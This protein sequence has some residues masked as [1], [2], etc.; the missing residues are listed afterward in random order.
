M[1]GLCKLSTTCFL[2]HTKYNV[3]KSTDKYSSKLK[4]S[5]FPAFEYTNPLLISCFQPDK[6]AQNNEF[7]IN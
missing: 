4:V 3:R 5:M 7:Y 6:P 2:M 1:Y